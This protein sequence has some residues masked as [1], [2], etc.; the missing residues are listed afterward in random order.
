MFSSICHQKRKYI[1]S[2]KFFSGGGGRSI[3]QLEN[4]QKFKIEID[5]F[6]VLVL[7][8]ERRITHT[9]MSFTKSLGQQMHGNFSI[10]RHTPPLLETEWLIR[11]I[12]THIWI[13]EYSLYETK[14]KQRERERE[15][16]KLTNCLGM[17]P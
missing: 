2:L 6:F 16:H 3:Q 5:V 15:N 10:S 14:C 11:I 17:M 8:Q 1:W 7:G 13:F 12:L 9:R 4:G